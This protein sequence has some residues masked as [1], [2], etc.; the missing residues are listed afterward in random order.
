MVLLSVPQQTVG[1]PVRVSRDLLGAVGAR[2]RLFERSARVVAVSGSTAPHQIAVDSAHESA[3]R[4]SLRTGGSA[5][6]IFS[7]VAPTPVWSALSAFSALSALALSTSLAALCMATTSS[8]DEVVAIPDHGR[9]MKSPRMIA[10]S[11]RH[12]DGAA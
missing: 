9:G 2:Y 3:P 7:T 1:E 6:R 12:P 8:G 11:H 4:R 5:R 10:S